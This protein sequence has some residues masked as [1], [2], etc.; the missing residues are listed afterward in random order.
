[1]D[2]PSCPTRSPSS[3][4]WSGWMDW[5][6]TQLVKNKNRINDALNQIIQLASLYQQLLD[7]L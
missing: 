2:T 5:T 1:M 7:S 4:T 3:P 6:L